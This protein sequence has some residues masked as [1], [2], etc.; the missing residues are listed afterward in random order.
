MFGLTMEKLFLVALVAAFILGPHRLPQ[1][2]A[3]LGRFVNE[4]RSFTAAARAT[5]EREA[6]AI[7]PVHEL[8]DLRRYDPRTILREA[9]RDGEADTDGLA[10]APA[11]A[12]MPVTLEETS[13]ATVSDAAFAPT[14]GDE[15]A[16]APGE[17][18][19]DPQ[20]ISASPEPMPSLRR[21][22]TVTGSSGHPRRLL[23]LSRTGAD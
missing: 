22:A 7:L 5:T 21:H 2:A 18:G 19:E 3:R 11:D 6:G 8:E 1:Y 17:L 23:E 9:L 14:V 12:A 20:A 16:A 15:A 10:P 4:L 13:A